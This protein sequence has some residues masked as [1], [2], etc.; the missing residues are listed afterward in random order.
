MR[1]SNS[2]VCRWQK[3]TEGFQ[4]FIYLKKTITHQNAVHV[5]Q[6]RCENYSNM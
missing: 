5:L 3:E 6:I 4:V 2:F 1:L